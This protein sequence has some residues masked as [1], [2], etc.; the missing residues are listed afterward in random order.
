M[1][2]RSLV[3]VA[4]AA[5]CLVAL[6]SW[7]H[8]FRA[9]T[10]FSAARVGAG[11]LPRPAPPL[12]AVDEQGVRFDVAEPGPSLRLVQAMYLRCPDVCPVAMA[13][14]SLIRRSLGELAPERVRIVSLS[15]DADPPSA[16]RDMWRA[17]GSPRGWTMASL[18][19]DAV[20]ETL[21][22]LGIWVFR[23]KD[24]LIN[25]ATDILL[26]DREGRVVRV[27]SADEDPEAIAE[28]VRE[29]AS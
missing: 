4:V 8:G 24:G 27:F 7:T 10:S 19:G 29:L 17:H 23:R 28:Q 2:L 22:R 1:K 5:V 11:Q 25:H 12:E 16:L 9:F 26:L 20:E 13:R 6:A 3:P 21:E 18:V 15:V 14:L